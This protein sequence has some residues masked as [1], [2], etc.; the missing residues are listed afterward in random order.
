[1]ASRYVGKH[2]R[3]RTSSPAR[4]VATVA[5]AP[6]IVAGVPLAAASPAAAAPESTWDR[7]AECESSGNWSINT[8]N[9]YYGGLQFSQGSWEWVGGT[10]YAPRADLASKSEQIAA[11]ERLLD[12]QGWGA[13]PACSAELGLSE[14]DKEGSAPAPVAAPDP[15]PVREEPRA[16]RSSSRG[17][18]HVV[19]PGETLSQIARDHG[20]SGGWE[21]VYAANRSVIANPNVIYIGQRL[22]MP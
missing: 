16:S 15:E 10:E 19:R 1:M 13:W 22:V 21:A 6:L 9:G 20:V 11:A 8:G 3:P 5:A 18:S 2:R 4:R 14:A 17:G 12:L 7:L